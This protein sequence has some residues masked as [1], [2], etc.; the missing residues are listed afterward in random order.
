[1]VKV[2]SPLMSG[3][4]SGTIGGNLTFRRSR[5]QNIAGTKPV[6]SNPNTVGQQQARTVVRVWGRLVRNFNINV[7][8]PVGQMATIKAF[9]NAQKVAPAT[10][11]SY[12]LR[13]ALP[14]NFATLTAIKVVWNALDAGEKAVWEAEALEARWNFG[15][16]ASLV[17]GA[18]AYSAG[19]LL[20][21]AQIALFNS[22]Y[23]PARPGD[24]PTAFA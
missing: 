8:K 5:G 13:N 10:W 12:G 1:M 22:G 16:V 9:Y 24:A 20:H 7:T 18:D 21:I 6:P 17:V 2:T 15:P 19:E 14:A 23:L 4:A 3:S 11:N